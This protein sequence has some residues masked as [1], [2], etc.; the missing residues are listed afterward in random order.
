MPYFISGFGWVVTVIVFTIISCTYLCAKNEFISDERWFAL[1]D[2]IKR[3]DYFEDEHS[4]ELQEGGSFLGGM[5]TI[6][7]IIWAYSLLGLTAFFFIEFNTLVTQALVPKTEQAVKG[8]RPDIWIVVKFI[9]YTGPCMPMT[10]LPK[11]QYNQVG[12]ADDK[13]FS[14]SWQG[15]PNGGNA[16][17]R[18]STQLR[19]A[20]GIS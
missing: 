14:M 10:Q 3:K 4:R 7:F 17:T 19:V 9:G 6:L 18:T 13:L 8:L 11:M 5:T 20:K 12:D 15:A 1:R 2:W 16:N